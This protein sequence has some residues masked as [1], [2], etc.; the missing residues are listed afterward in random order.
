ML[1]SEALEQLKAGKSLYRTGWNPQDGYI[2][3]MQGMT[4]AWKI[5]LSPAPN[6][7]NY[8]FSVEDLLSDDWAEYEY[9]KPELLN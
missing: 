6:A 4:H 7:G 3:L 8:I 9:A 1:L 5:V 2:V